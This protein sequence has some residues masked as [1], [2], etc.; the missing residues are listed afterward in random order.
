M[1]RLQKV[2][3]DEV[4]VIPDFIGKGVDNRKVKGGHILDIQ[5]NVFLAARKKSGKTSTIF[6]ILKECAGRDTIVV[7]F[8]S[9]LYKD[10]GW[11]NI[12][13]YLDMKGITHLDF[14]SIK[15]ENGVDQLDSIVK[16]LEEEAKEEELNKDKPKEKKQSILLCEG[17]ECEDEH[18]KRKSKYRCPEYIFVFDDISSELKSKSL[19]S[20]L[21]RNRH[22]NATILLSSQYIL[23]LDPQSRKQIDTWL[24]FRGQPMEKLE[25]IYKDADISIPFDE[26]VRVYKVATEKPY[27]F[28]NINTRTE[29]FKKNF[30]VEIK[31]KSPD[32]V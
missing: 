25:T 10:V 11:L 23:D 19:I 14:T 12:R 26:F 24:V 4:T 18:K 16:E 5:H 27:S 13:K 15:D 2:H 3:N 21:K 1:L 32:I 6:K 20:L 7:L 28:L 17:D 30:N 22:Y 9:T 31:I 29:V 8:V